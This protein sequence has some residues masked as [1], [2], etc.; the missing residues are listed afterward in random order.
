MARNGH[1]QKNVADI[2]RTNQSEI[3]RV[4]RGE[5]KRL[6]ATVQRL[7][8]YAKYEIT[9]SPRLSEAE[10]RLSQVLREAV[11]NNSAAAIALTRIIES[12]TPLLHALKAAQSP[13]SEA[14]HDEA[15][16]Q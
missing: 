3:S 13:P 14:S 2:A 8:Q 6:T 12:V 10:L 11:G 9:D 5:R 4:L 16:A 15:S 1:S 7:C